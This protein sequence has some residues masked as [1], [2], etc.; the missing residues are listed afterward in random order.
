MS[1]IRAPDIS[2]NLHPISRQSE[3]AGATDGRFGKCV[4]RMTLNPQITD[5]VGLYTGNPS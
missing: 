1:R 3:A 2:V 4:L 5:N